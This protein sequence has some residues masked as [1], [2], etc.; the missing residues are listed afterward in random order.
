MAVAKMTKVI[1]ACFRDQANELL[2][3]LQKEGIFEIL[4][5]QRA[6]VSKEWP[7]LQTEIKK[8]RDLEDMVTRLQKSIDFLKDN[9][10]EKDMT[11]L[12]RPLIK[13]DKQK[14]SQVVSGKEA[15][16]LLL[17]TEHA[18]SESDRL[19]T[20]IENKCGTCE[21]LAPWENLEL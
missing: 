9:A 13:I 8:P 11:S 12:F 3:E 1:I 15:I 19:E 16:E 10:K 7:E 2:E 18:I 21:I 14:Y 5:A 4:D 17:A 6:M 20:E